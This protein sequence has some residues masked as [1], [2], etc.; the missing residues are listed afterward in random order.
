[1][2]HNTIR[3][4]AREAGVSVAS[5]SRTMND[6]PGVLPATR[7]R[8]LEAA[9]KLDYV[10]HAG[11]RNLSMAKANA[12]GVVLP[13]LHGEFF[14]EL[15]RGI[16]QQAQTLGYQMLLSNMHA[17][18]EQAAL[19]LRTMRGRVD[20]ML[21]MAPELSPEFLAESLPAGLKM[22]LMNTPAPDGYP[23]LQFENHAGAATMTRHLLR[24]GARRVVHLAGPASNIDARQRCEGYCAVM[25]ETSGV[26]AEIIPGDFSEAAG[27]AAVRHL[28]PRIDEVD[29]IFAANDMMAIGCLLA[30]RDAGID[31]PGQVLVAG[32]DDIP[33]TRY[34]MPG[35]TTMR[36]NI[37][38]LGA[39]AMR[40]LDALVSGAETPEHLPRLVPD[41]IVRASTMRDRA[42]T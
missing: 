30:F 29:A 20:G 35:L 8:V 14:S 2:A 26:A 40:W 10:P 22:V 38:D 7:E 23:S 4:V 42:G 33:A 41:L 19:A 3:D 28:L 13:D 6:H 11:A 5:V 31:V 37:A 16:D 1:M 12:I 39:G 27:A 21:I 18:P 15:L 24:S 32:F 25:A 36:V 17:D 34:L 9:R